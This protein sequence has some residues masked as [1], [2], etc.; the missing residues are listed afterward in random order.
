ML[1][2]IVMKFNA[3]LV[4]GMLLIVFQSSALLA[5]DDPEY[6]S[7]A[8]QYYQKQNYS[9][10]YKMYLKLAKKGDHSAQS[11]VATMNAGGEGKKTDL[12]EAYA[13]STLAAESGD[14]ELLRRSEDLFQ[15][16]SDK[17][18]AEKKAAKLQKKY[19]QTA[20]KERAEKRERIRR[21]HEMGGCT[22]GKLGCSG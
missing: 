10:A 5:S 3:I 16:V 2:L 7:E 21:R 17:T 19:S 8:D 13:W 1:N 22:G 20:L 11:Q 4:F 9:K 6:R 14:E 15:Q 12:M 18:K